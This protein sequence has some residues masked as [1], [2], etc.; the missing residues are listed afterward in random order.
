M[1]TIL[2]NVDGE[3]ASRFGETLDQ[4]RKQQVDAEEYAEFVSR[5][6]NIISQVDEI[7]TNEQENRADLVEEKERVKAQYGEEDLKLLREDGAD[8][9]ELGETGV[10]GEIRKVN[11]RLEDWYT[12]R[13]ELQRV[14]ASKLEDALEEVDAQSVRSQVYEEL[15]K[16]QKK[17]GELLEERQDNLK[18]ELRKEIKDVEK[19]LKQER[20]E[21]RQMLREERKRDWDVIMDVLQ[22]AMSV[23]EDFGQDV[24]TLRQRVTT[25]DESDLS[26]TMDSAVDEAEDNAEAPEEAVEP[27]YR[28]KDKSW[29]ERQQELQRLVETEDVAE[30]SKQQ[31]VEL[32]DLSWGGFYDKTEGVLGKLEK[33]F[34]D[35]YPELH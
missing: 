20:K 10:E 19:E 28:F 26:V 33:K 25:R 16:I 8:L 29:E 12:Y 6:N 2:S 35:Q 9:V 13:S 1:S 21:F 22:K 14:K 30:L 24:S 23:I 15:D 4:L 7:I 34:G 17:R 32:M 11:R 31:I 5:V 18:R 3:K 27:K